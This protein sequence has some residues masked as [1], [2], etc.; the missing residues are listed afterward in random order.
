MPSDCTA[1]RRLASP[2][3]AGMPSIHCYGQSSQL[4]DITSDPFT[5][6][7][8]AVQFCITIWCSA[9]GLPIWYFGSH[10]VT[11]P[12]GIL[13]AEVSTPV[14]LDTVAAFSHGLRSGGQRRQAWIVGSC[15]H[16]RWNNE[17]QRPRGN[18]PFFKEIVS[19]KWLIA[20]CK[21]LPGVLYSSKELN[22]R[23]EHRREMESTPSGN[24][25][26]VN[27]LFI[28]F[29]GMNPEERMINSSL[30]NAGNFLKTSAILSEV[31]FYWYRSSEEK[32]FFQQQRF[33][34]QCSKP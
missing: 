2:P 23:N 28:P 34:L 29:I 22:D 9:A 16:A 26:R 14:W 15:I 24:P 18:R 20:R 21:G 5:R 27:Q 4:H 32:V 8:P 12:L 30:W 6:H 17:N 1:S 13:Q 19:E 7:C 31:V 10:A 33:K 3:P 25:A 11:S